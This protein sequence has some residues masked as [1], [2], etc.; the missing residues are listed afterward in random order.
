[1]NKKKLITISILPIMWL[2]YCLFELVAGRLTKGYDIIMMILP[3]LLFALV[4][5]IF[6]KISETYKSGLNKNQ[7]LVLFI[8][9]MIIDQGIKLVI[10]LWFF[11]VNFDIIPNFLSFHPIINTQGSWLN[12]RFGTGL[13]FQLLIL[14]NVIALFIFTECYRYYLHKGNKDI[15][16][17]LTYIFIVAGALCSLIDKIFYGGSLDFIGISNLFIADLKDIYINLAIFFFILNIYINDYW[18]EDDN[19]TLKDDLQSIK[20]FFLFVKMDITKNIF[21]KDI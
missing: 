11:D 5:Y 4:G 3:A 19:T 7:L 2:I 16:A 8:L 15:F 18:K 9:L 12:A 20:R 21:R 13:D 10:K 17:D 6:F 14:V 1:M